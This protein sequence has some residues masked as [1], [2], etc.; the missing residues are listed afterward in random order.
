LS[1]RPRVDDIVGADD[2]RH[3]RCLELGVDVV[4]VVDEVVRHAGFGQQ[5]VHVARH[6]ARHRVDRELHLHPAVDQELDELPDLVLRLRHRHAVARHDGTFGVGHHA[7]PSRHRWASGCRHLLPAAAAAD[8]RSC[9]QHV[10]D[11]SG[12]S[13]WPS[14]A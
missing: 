4:H 13:P 11:A 2:E 5:H 14:A 7:P 10:A 6:A 9:E 1:V 8:R 3:V 12:S